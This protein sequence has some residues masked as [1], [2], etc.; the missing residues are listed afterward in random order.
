MNEIEAMLEQGR[1][2]LA[3][4]R[5]QAID[6]KREA[7]NRE[8]AKLAAEWAAVID[9]VRADLPPAIYPFAATDM[10]EPFVRNGKSDV[11]IEIVAPGCAPIYARYRYDTQTE[12]WGRCQHWIPGIGDQPIWQVR[13]Y[14]L[15]AR[16][17]DPR[18]WHFVSDLSIALAMAAESF[19]ERERSESEMV[20]RE[21]ARRENR[22][23][24][25]KTKEEWVL[26]LLAQFVQERRTRDEEE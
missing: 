4:Q 24:T 17:A 7:E 10:P 25:A 1:E 16:A 19:T 22:K 8:H 9:E 5:Q 2:L 18:E 21:Q 23:L 12:K 26:D 15:L 13:Y 6:A 11:L 3:V 20:E 14:N